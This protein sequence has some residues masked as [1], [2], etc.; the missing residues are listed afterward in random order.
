MRRGQPNY[1]GNGGVKDLFRLLKEE[2]EWLRGALVADKVVGKGAAAL[3]VLGGVEEL[4]TEVISRPALELLE[5]HQVR[6]SFTTLV[7]QISNR[8][9]TGPCPIESRCSG[10]QTPEECLRKIEEFIL[11]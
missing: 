4:Y 5:R 10:C 3:M 8:T 9:Q 7:E 2:P 1:F 6:V 11:S